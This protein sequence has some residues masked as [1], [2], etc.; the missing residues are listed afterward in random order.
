LNQ[1][2]HILEKPCQHVRSHGLKF[3]GD[4]CFQGVYGSWFVLVNKTNQKKKT[5]PQPNDRK[6]SREARQ[7]GNRLASWRTAAQCRNN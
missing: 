7:A 3:F 4:V 1:D 5:N 6:I 2:S